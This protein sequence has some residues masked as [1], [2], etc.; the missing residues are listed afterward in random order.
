MR[1]KVTHPE[2]KVK[3]LPTELMKDHGVHVNT[4]G[5]AEFASQE[6]VSVWHYVVAIK[7]LPYALARFFNRSEFPKLMQGKLK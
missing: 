6:E 1:G 3:I 7:G 4:D 2:T 5:K